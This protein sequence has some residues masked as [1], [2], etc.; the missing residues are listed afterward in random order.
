MGGMYLL[1]ACLLG[2]TDLAWEG[3]ATPFNLIVLFYAS[4]FAFVGI[5]RLLQIVLGYTQ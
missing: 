5:I 1:F 4:T 2:F 3:K